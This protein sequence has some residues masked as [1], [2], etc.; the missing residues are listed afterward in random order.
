MPEENEVLSK[1]DLVAHIAQIKDAMWNAMSAQTRR[2]ARKGD[3]PFIKNYDAQVHQVTSWDQALIYDDV[4]YL[5][6]MI[7]QHHEKDAEEWIKE[8]PENVYAFFSQGNVPER[9]VSDFKIAP[10]HVHQDDK[11]AV[12]TM[13]KKAKAKK[14]T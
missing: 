13:V 11:K 14:A 10:K 9:F 12:Y 1:D 2:R 7:A 3:L 8:K 6:N 4:I 5:L